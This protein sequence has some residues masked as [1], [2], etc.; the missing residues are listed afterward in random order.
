MVWKYICNKN[1]QQKCGSGSLAVLAVRKQ[2]FRSLAVK[3]VRKRNF[4]QCRQSINAEAV[5]KIFGSQ[6]R[7]E[8]YKQ[9]FRSSAVMAEWKCGSG[10]S[11]LL[12]SWQSGS[13]VRTSDLWQSRQSRSVETELHIFCSQGITEVPK[14]NFRSLVVKAE[15]KCG[16]GSSP[17]WQTLPN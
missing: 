15:R 5:F 16:S 7:A 6:G 4:S 8:V 9:N 3:T 2:N 14:Q 1:I 10:S 17:L 11:D 12:Q 13:A